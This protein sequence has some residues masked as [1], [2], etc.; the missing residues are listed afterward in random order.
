[1]MDLIELKSI[2]YSKDGLTVL[3]DVSFTVPA[4]KIVTL[5]GPNGAGKTTLL[6]IVLGILAPTAGKVVKKSGLKIGYVPQKLNIPATIPLTVRR[7]MTLEKAYSDGDIAA[8]LAQT[9]AEKLADRSIHP[10]SGGE[11]QRVLLA[12]A[13]L[14]NPDVLVLDEPAQGLD[15]SGEEAL[16]GLIERLNKERGCAVL[17]VSHDLYVVMAKTDKVVCLNRH[18]CCSGKPQDVAELTPYMTL[19]RHHHDHTHLPDGSICHD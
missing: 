16:Y 8:A 3:E 14:Q 11:T 15:P 9:G 4:G 10:L 2:G 1:M 13:L 5:I 18:V 17:M 6:K 12:R 19:Y 7:F